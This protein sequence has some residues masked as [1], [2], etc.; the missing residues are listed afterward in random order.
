[1][2][3]ISNKI[4]LATVVSG[5]IAI[6]TT[7]TQAKDIR[8]TFGSL[9]EG[10]TPFLVNTAF[11]KAVNKYMPGHKISVSAVGT[12]IKHQLNVATGKMDFSIGGPMG[13]HL[14]YRQVGPFRKLKKGQ[15][16]KLLN[17]L[18]SIFSYPVGLYHTVVY[19]GSGIKA[20]GD[21]KGKKVYLGPPGGP[22]TRN[23]G[24]IIQAMTGYV[25]GKD[26]TQV[27]MGW[28]P[29]QKA[30]QDKKFDVW[31]TV[32]APPGP[33]VQQLTLGNKIRLLPLI[34]S[35]YSNPIWKK[36]MMAPG[37]MMDKIDPKLYGKN[38]VNTELVPSTGAWVG[39]YARASIPADDMYN[40]MKAFWDHIDEAYALSAQLKKTLTLENAVA[41]MSGN[42][43]PG[44]LR[45]YKEKGVKIG[46]V[47]NYDKK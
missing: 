29:A 44:A 17:N 21:L 46:K 6:G 32:T 31:T 22:T 10:S 8:Y 39:I 7:T 40:M 2:T 34:E 20:F 30:F 42:V 18:T 19:A 28:G 16:P 45:Y 14:M 12:G 26:Y 3:N 15:G 33:N 25:P 36:Y 43:H 4:L 35:R 11:A 23:M 37:R 24:L 38:I 41:A 13:Y 5:V 27:K 1:M 9:P 47:L